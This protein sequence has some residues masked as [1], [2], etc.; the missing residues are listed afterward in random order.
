MSLSVLVGA[1]ELGCI[2]GLASLGLTISLRILNLP[3][4]TVDGSFVT[5]MACSAVAVMFGQPLLGVLL[6]LI[7]GGLA[8]LMTGVLHTKFNIQAILAGIL[9]MTASYS[10]NLKIMNN[11]PSLFF[12]NDKTIFSDIGSLMVGGV[13]V[14]KL[15]VLLI[16]CLNVIVF[17]RIF[18]KTTVGLALRATGDN[19]EMVRS[20][21]INTDQMKILGFVITNSVVALSGAIYAQYNQAASHGAGAGILVLCCASIIIGETIFFKK[22]LNQLFVAVLLGSIVYRLMIT[23]AF[24]VGLPA[25]DLK[26]FSAIIVITALALPEIKKRGKKRARA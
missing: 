10:I 2:F 24:Y 14:S 20:S 18:F 9:T 4:L 6:A 15:I 5:G 23:F 17:Y 7:G 26:L 19:E 1:C 11:Q 3:D 22:G 16:I 25:S 8:G 12:Y 21:S 13:D